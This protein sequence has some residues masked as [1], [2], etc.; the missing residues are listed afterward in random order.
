MRKMKEVREQ[1][2]QIIMQKVQSVKNI[3]DK[4]ETKDAKLVILERTLGVIDSNKGNL[5]HKVRNMSQLEKN[6][7]ALN[8]IQTC[9]H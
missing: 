1:E 9:K 7:I 2:R 4:D 8:M 5:G 3:F 6:R